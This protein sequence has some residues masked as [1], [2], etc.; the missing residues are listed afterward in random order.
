MTNLKI[1]KLFQNFWKKENGLT[2][3]FILVVINNFVLQQ[4]LIK[5]PYLKVYT[6]LIWL[7]IF[8][9]GVIATSKT[10][11]QAS[12]LTSIPFI[13]VLIAGFHVTN[14]ERYLAFIL[15]FSQISFLSIIIWILLVKVFERGRVDIQ[16]IF[17]SIVVFILIGNLW[18]GAYEFIYHQIPGSIA[19]PPST[20]VDNTTTAAFIYYSFSTLTTTGYGEF[21]PVHPV[22]RSLA[23]MEQLIGVLYPV[24]LIGR[25]VS[26]EI[27]H[28]KPTNKKPTID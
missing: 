2:Y 21:V 20:I 25:L 8:I 28:K 15:F 11:L 23:S 26:L 12:I 3:M 27:E 14:N 4:Y 13:S 1:K 7:F 5:H 19:V 6:G 16:R 22:A 18:G 10:K 9:S 24:I 17:G